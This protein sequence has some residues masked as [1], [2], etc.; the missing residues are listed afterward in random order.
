MS[1]HI[2][3]QAQSS[4]VTIKAVEEC[5]RALLEDG[6]LLSTTTRLCSTAQTLIVASCS[7]NARDLLGIA[8]PHARVGDV[9]AL[10]SGMSVPFVLRKVKGTSPNKGRNR[11]KKG[12]GK[13]K[14]EGGERMYEVVGACY[15]EGVMQGE[16]WHEDDEEGVGEIEL[17]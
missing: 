4:P 14:E 7:S 12:K 15:L 11:K 9:I 8:P 17:V 2:P 5:A 13:K 3:S 16:E 1:S 6:N 10:L